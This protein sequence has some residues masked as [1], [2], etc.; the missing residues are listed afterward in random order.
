M[1]LKIYEKDVDID[2]FKYLLMGFMDDVAIPEAP[3]FVDSLAWG[4]M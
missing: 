1:K 4:Q 2:H 3:L